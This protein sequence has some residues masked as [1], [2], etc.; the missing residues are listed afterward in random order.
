MTQQRFKPMFHERIG[1]FKVWDNYLN[2]YY[3]YET[4]NFQNENEC[5]DYINNITDTYTVFYERKNGDTFIS[6]NYYNNLKAVK[7]L[8]KK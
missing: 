3:K 2:C 5:K 1:T 8:H 7:R 4:L 6:E